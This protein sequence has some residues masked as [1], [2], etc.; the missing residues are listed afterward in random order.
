LANPI[1]QYVRR[2]LQSPHHDRIAAGQNEKGHHMNANPMAPAI[3]V[4]ATEIARDSQATTVI[5]TA[6]VKGIRGVALAGIAAPATI[7]KTSEENGESA[8][9]VGLPPIAQAACP[10]RLGSARANRQ[11]EAIRVAPDR[12]RVA[13]PAARA[14]P[15][16]SPSSRKSRKW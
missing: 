5:A 14:A 6:T 3:I 15:A 13:D 8:T 11:R 16:K 10:A 2:Y 7:G 1:S 12:V 9:I 4:I